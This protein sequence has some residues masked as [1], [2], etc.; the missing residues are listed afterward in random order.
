MAAYNN[1][2]NLEGS[3]EPEI[4]GFLAP[5]A[6]FGPALHLQAQNPSQHTENNDGDGPP[7]AARRPRGRPPGSKNKPKPP[8][9][10]TRDSANA[11][12][13]HVLEVSLGAELMESLSTYACRRG[14]GVCVLSGTGTVA[15]VALRQPAGSVLTFPGR[16]EIVSITG[17]VLPPPA[18]PGSAGLS[19]YLSGAQGQ[20]VGGIVVAPLVASSDVVLVAAS[21]ANAML[22]RLPLLPLNHHH[23][24]DDEDPPAVTGS[25][26][27]G[28]GRNNPFS[29]WL[30]SELFE[31]G[32]SGSASS[33]APPKPSPF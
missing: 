7:N 21:F 1:N 16:F 2:N 32:G 13:S 5:R 28:D 18:P 3:E 10:V 27:V 6:L 23:D 33:H 19:V 15:N 31:L 22:E 17:T 29:W 20:V 9:I 11:L 25:G 4:G 30:Q 12:H 8:V 24:D 26:H 14:R